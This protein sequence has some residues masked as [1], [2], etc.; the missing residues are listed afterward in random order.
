MITQHLV[1]QYGGRV[2][3]DSKLG[4]GSCFSFKLKLQQEQLQEEGLIQEEPLNRYKFLWKPID[5]TQVQY[6]Q[7]FDIN[8]ADQMIECESSDN[9]VRLFSFSE[10]EDTLNMFTQNSL[11]QSYESLNHVFT[12]RI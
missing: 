5:N 8:N 1:D 6:V 7:D 2:I 11:I 4:I 3:V 9:T 12:D 10:N